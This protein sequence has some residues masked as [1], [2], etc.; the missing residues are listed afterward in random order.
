M[1]LARYRAESPPVVVAREYR[2]RERPVSFN[3]QDLLGDRRELHAWVWL[4]RVNDRSE[5][6]VPDR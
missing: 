6:L 5:L 3:N 1:L 4:E 2:A